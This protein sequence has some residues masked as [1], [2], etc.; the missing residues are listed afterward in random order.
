VL[1]AV[2]QLP[3]TKLFKFGIFA[4][5]QFLSRLH[6]WPQYSTCLTKIPHLQQIRPDIFEAAEK[7]ALA[8]QAAA[9]PPAQTVAPTSAAAVA[10]TEQ[11]TLKVDIDKVTEFKPSAKLT[12]AVDAKKAAKASPAPPPDP[13]TADKM[14]FIINNV[15][16]SN[17]EQ[18]AEDMKAVFKPEQHAEYLAQYLVA[19][20]ISIEPNNHGLYQSFIESVGS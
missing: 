10:A 8:G 19:T 7:V 4:L 5:E 12:Q 3:G 16:L 18:K 20:R 6:D 9:P 14:H 15:S 2:R 11:N 13:A 1:D 17:L